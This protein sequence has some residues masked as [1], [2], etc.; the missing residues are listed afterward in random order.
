MDK[1]S[2]VKKAISSLPKKKKA[3]D[4][5][6][7]S[8]VEYLTKYV[9]SPMFK[10]RL[11]KQA[12]TERKLQNQKYGKYESEIFGE[13]KLTEPL[14][15]VVA[16]A[17]KN[18]NENIKKV[19]PG[20]IK[21][22]E[23]DLG[24]D[25]AGAYD[26]SVGDIRIRKDMLPKYKSV[27]THEL[28]HASTGGKQPLTGTF[29]KQYLDNIFKA[30]GMQGGESIVQSPK[31]VKA[32]IDAVRFLA[33]KRGIYDAGTEEFNQSHLE[34]LKKDPEVSK[35]FNFIQLMDQLKNN[36]KNSGFIWMMNNIAKSKSKN[37]DS[38]LA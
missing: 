22:G 38:N 25:V 10:K 3:D 14:Q 18:F 17:I 30:P 23:F 6:V 33:S 9:N 29:K 26:S 31:E 36:K 32:R 7:S 4:D 1:S 15:S 11:I 28:S 2:I 35:D 20:K 16:K 5:T 19:A 12:A 34:K 24:K 37:N 13:S 27:V 21:V 8:Q